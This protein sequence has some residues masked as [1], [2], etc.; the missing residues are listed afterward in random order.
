MIQ[1]TSN[2]IVHYDHAIGRYVALAEDTRDR[3]IWRFRSAQSGILAQREMDGQIS[4]WHFWG[5]REVAMRARDRSPWPE[6]CREAMLEA[7]H[8]F[9]CLQEA[10]ELASAARAS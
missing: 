6:A 5:T 8:G 7:S 4:P 10:A 2:V 3:A 1:V 9:P